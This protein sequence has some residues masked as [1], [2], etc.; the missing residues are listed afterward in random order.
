M[1]AIRHTA[2]REDAAAGQ[3]GRCRAVTAAGPTCS[4]T[5]HQRRPDTHWGILSSR[6][7]C[8]P[9]GLKPAARRGLSM[10]VHTCS[11][12]SVEILTVDRFLPQDSPP[13]NVPTASHRLQY[14]TAPLLCSTELDCLISML[15]IVSMNL[16]TPVLL[17]VR[18]LA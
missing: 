5:L 10:C 6:L 8:S 7:R 4:S 17:C 9:V 11:A 15:L 13:E 12:S 1:P 14:V 2:V 3:R 18:P 16:L